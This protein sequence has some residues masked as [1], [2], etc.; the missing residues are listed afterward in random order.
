MKDSVR[1]MLDQDKAPTAPLADYLE[2]E[3]EDGNLW[4]RID[5]GHHLNL[6]EEAVDALTE[7]AKEK[8]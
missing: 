7:Y 6:F 1:R 3:Q 5:C 2:A 4:W 8:P